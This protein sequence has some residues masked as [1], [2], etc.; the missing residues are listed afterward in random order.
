LLLGLK[1]YS[2]NFNMDGS[3]TLNID[4]IGAAESGVEEVSADVLVNSYIYDIQAKN[5]ESKITQDQEKLKERKKEFEQQIGEKRAR[6]AQLSALLQTQDLNTQ[7]REEAALLATELDADNPNGIV[8]KY[9][10]FESAETESIEKNKKAFRNLK[11]SSFMTYL[12]SVN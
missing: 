1:T 10:N 5:L 2:F 8:Q 12:F 3:V 11:Y 6:Q 7:Q 9:S 4:F